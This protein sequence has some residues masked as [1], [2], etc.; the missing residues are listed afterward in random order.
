MVVM[1]KDGTVAFDDYNLFAASPSLLLNGVCLSALKASGLFENVIGAS[2]GASSDVSVEVFVERLALDC[3]Q[4]GARRA[5][6]EILVR[7]LKG[8]SIMSTTEGE[9]SVDASDG[10][11]G[12]A[13]SKA[14]SSA[15]SS[16]L[17]KMR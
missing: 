8:R 6:V 7:V 9:E 5:V 16:A 15:V 13:F 14:V 12:V 11:Y 1:R 4:E 17:S 3:R 10:D 2:S